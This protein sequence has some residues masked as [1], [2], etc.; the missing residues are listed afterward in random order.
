MNEDL[1]GGGAFMNITIVAQAILRKEV[2]IFASE[3]YKVME[4]KKKVLTLIY[5][6]SV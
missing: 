2:V 6:F 3:Q 4:R 5:T 1:Q